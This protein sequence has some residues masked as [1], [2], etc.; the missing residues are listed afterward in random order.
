MLRAQG[1]RG[2]AELS[3][4]FVTEAEIAS[5]N[6]RFMDKAGPT[7]VLSFPLL[8]PEAYPPHAGDPDRG[9]DVPAGSPVVF[10]GPRVDITDKVIKALNAQSGAAPAAAPTTATTPPK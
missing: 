1:V 7:D 4:I 10:A 3:L 6:E 5:L 9:P 2:L 8:P